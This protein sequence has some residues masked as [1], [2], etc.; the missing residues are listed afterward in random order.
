M[1]NILKALDAVDNGVNQYDT[2]KLPR[3]VNNTYLSTRVGRLN[4][5]WLEPNTPE[6]ENKSFSLAMELAGREFL[7]VRKI[8]LSF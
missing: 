4:P 1:L 5:D 7:N 2:D 6:V 8:N 3:Y